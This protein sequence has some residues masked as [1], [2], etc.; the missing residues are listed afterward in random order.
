VCVCGDERSDER[1]G[2]WS[3]GEGGGQRLGPHTS[4]RE[5]PCRQYGLL[6]IMPFAKFII[7]APIP[8]QNVVM[9]VV[10]SV[11]VN[12]RAVKEVVNV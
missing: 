9:N 2:E 6:E 10:M 1:G 11:V 8:P 4:I 12:G 3:G 7:G 5:A